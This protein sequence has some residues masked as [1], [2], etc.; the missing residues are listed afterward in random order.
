MPFAGA[1]HGLRTGIPDEADVQ[2]HGLLQWASFM[3]CTCG[4]K[5]LYAVK[6]FEAC[7]EQC[8]SMQL[9]AALQRAMQAF[10]AKHCHRMFANS[11]T[12]ASATLRHVMGPEG[13]FW[14]LQACQLLKNVQRQLQ[15]L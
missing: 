8:M 14:E 5:K 9:R 1:L 13:V 2:S 4:K 15:S 11:A 10:A 3:Y 6:D 7:T 12:T